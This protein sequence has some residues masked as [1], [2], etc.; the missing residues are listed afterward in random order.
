MLESIK[1]AGKLFVAGGLVCCWRAAQT[2]PSNDLAQLHDIHLPKPIGW[3]PLASGWY[4][5]GGL[6]LGLLIIIAYML[7]AHYYQGGAKRQALRLLVAYEQQHARERN[8]QLSSARISELLR[9]VALVYF[10][11]EQV[12]G[13]QGESWLHFLNDSG[14]NMDFTVVSAVLLQQ[15]YQPKDIQGNLPL[16]FTMAK[17]WISQRRKPCSN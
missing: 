16:L 8:S 15:P 11:R 5:L 12:A 7:I 10:P 6:L 9:R 3:W 17:T 2:A 4:V 14:K 1:A 13:L